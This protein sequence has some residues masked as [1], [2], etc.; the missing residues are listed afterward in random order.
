MSAQLHHIR[1]SQNLHEDFVGRHL[2]LSMM[3]S[4]VHS[5][6]MDLLQQTI[7][8][9]LASIYN[10]LSSYYPRNSVVCR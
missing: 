7:V 2:L 5:R 1:I 9:D 4:E 3:L 8:N 6:V 10:L